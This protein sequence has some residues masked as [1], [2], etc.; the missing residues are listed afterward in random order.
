MDNQG[1]GF[2][3]PSFPSEPPTSTKLG[4]M[5]SF[6]T[7]SQ[8][9][10]AFPY[11]SKS[12][13]SSSVS[14]PKTSALKGSMA[15][16][17]SNGMP[18]QIVTKTKAFGNVY[19]APAFPAFQTPLRGRES[20]GGGDVKGFGSTTFTPGPKSFG[21]F[22]PKGSTLVAP[23]KQSFSPIPSPFE[24]A[25]QK[26][27]VSRQED[28]GNMVGPGFKSESVSP[29]QVSPT[30]SKSF[31]M[32]PPKG[33]LDAY[34]A[35]SF[36]GGRIPSSSFGNAP[37]KGA[38]GGGSTFTPGMP[39]KTD[40]GESPKS[41]AKASFKKA[42]NSKSPY[43]G[44]V[45]GAGGPVVGTPPKAESVLSSQSSFGKAPFKGSDER[46][47]PLA[48]GGGGSPSKAA[49]ASFGNKALAK[50]PGLMKGPFG[51]SLSADTMGAKKTS[52][53]SFGG[54]SSPFGKATSQSPFGGGM[55]SK[56]VSSSFGKSPLKGSADST[57]PFGGDGGGMPSVKAG[58]TPGS[59]GK[60]PLKGAAGGGSTFTP[61]MPLK[62]DS[63]E[64]PKSFAK[65]SFNKAS[66]SKS[67]YGG[68]V[69]G[70]GGP[71]VGTP[72][73]AESVLSSQSSFGKAPFKGS[74]ER[75][76]TSSFG[77]SSPFGKATSQSPFGGGM[78]SKAVSSSFGKSPLK[79]SA[80]STSP[81]GG[82]GGGMPSVKAGPTPGSFG[83]ASL[84]GAAGGGSTFTPGTGMSS[85]AE[86]FGY[87]PPY[88]PLFPN[89]GG[90]IA[91]SDSLFVAKDIL[92]DAELGRGAPEIASDEPSTLPLRPKA[93]STQRP[94]FGLGGA[95]GKSA[96]RQ[97]DFGS[98]KSASLMHPKG[99]MLKG[100]QAD[101]FFSGL[102]SASPPNASTPAIKRQLQQPPQP[103]RPSFG[104]PS[105]DSGMDQIPPKS[106]RGAPSLGS[107][108]N[109]F[110]GDVS[111]QRRTMRQPTADNIS[112]D[113]NQFASRQSVRRQQQPQ[114]TANVPRRNIS[115]P[116]PQSAYGFQQ[117]PSNWRNQA[118]SS[119]IGQ[120]SSSVRDTQRARG[121]LL[122]SLASGG[123]Q[124]S[125]SP[126]G[127]KRPN[128]TGPIDSGQFY[129]GGPIDN[130]QFYSGG[131]GGPGDYQYREV[132]VTDPR[133][134][135]RRTIRVPPPNLGG[136]N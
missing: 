22:S 30:A 28:I 87:T 73:K 97:P 134:G 64:S 103:G 84:K 95:F 129:S 88:A 40:S 117:G 54:G 43:G 109:P 82:D 107:N 116:P 35:S 14:G 42:S 86:S 12:P 62:T 72:P 105:F 124:Q 17:Q 60:A 56:A 136:N 18:K 115:Q 106:S 65:A 5:S 63:G 93:A 2:S 89:K 25:P 77:G 38:A 3:Q 44:G 119:P 53:S 112:P 58:P 29:K 110:A 92:L 34:A 102:K 114:P 13:S 127:S 66:N 50:D 4:D 21:K 120:I 45:P 85:N 24:K 39:L 91:E 61:G 123:Q 47:I 32:S 41:F 125:L 9:K 74:D 6:M 111:R 19:P 55:P 15:G 78:P 75:M 10:S 16:Q 118:V 122:G 1:G 113:T 128:A 59:F 126:A 33:A 67:P 46:M 121:T 135:D 48:F 11:M 23:P 8:P 96:P 104:A 68:G 57:S 51:K 98:P 133:T 131:S 79:G 81:F 36:G 69:P 94:V 27:F 52:T 80:D 108:V 70:A 90:I 99:S 100:Q 76:S 7:N 31:G 26:G 130:D 83:K 20:T 49:D 101:G 37:L 132:T 71:V